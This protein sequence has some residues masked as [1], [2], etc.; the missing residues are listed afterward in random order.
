MNDTLKAA[1]NLGAEL[2]AARAEN[3]RLRGLLREAEPYVMAR[4]VGPMETSYLLQRIRAALSQQAEPVCPFCGEPSDHCNQSFPHPSK[5]APAQDER[6][7]EGVEVVGHLLVDAVGGNA[8]DISL[9]DIVDCQ[10][11]YG[12]EIV[13]VMTVVQHQNILSAVTAER[14]RLLVDLERAHR[15]TNS[16]RM[17]WAREFERRNA[18]QAERDRLRA[19]V[20]ALRAFVTECAGTAGGMVNGNK[21]SNR[22]KELIAAMDAKEE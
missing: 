21:L 9:N 17:D 15:A 12:G 13:G 2:G 3:E 4:A 10:R 19:E 20:E 5:P 1:G 11:R 8:I 18:V 16:E 7:A 6:E 22:A 14:D